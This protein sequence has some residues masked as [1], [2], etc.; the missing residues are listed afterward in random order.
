MRARDA[1]LLHA[2]ASMPSRLWT[3]RR[4]VHILA[5]VAWLRVRR[6]VQQWRKDREQADAPNRV[7]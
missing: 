4:V 2:G 7:T 1:A 6:D 5:P 3:C